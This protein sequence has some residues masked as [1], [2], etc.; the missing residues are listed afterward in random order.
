M[1]PRLVVY[2]PLGDPAVLLDLIDVYDGEGVD[3]VECGWPALDPYLDGPDVR[4]SMAR[5]GE[6]T[7]AWAAVRERRAG[8]DAKP[9]VDDLRWA[10]SYG[11][12]GAAARRLAVP[13]GR[14][15]GRPRRATLE[16]AARASGAKVCAFLPLPLTG[17]DVAEARRAD[18]YVMLQAAPGVTGPRPS[19]DPANTERLTRLRTSGVVAPVVLGFGISNGAQA[20]TA[21]GLGAD[22]VVVG[23]AALR[24]GARG[25]DQGFAEGLDG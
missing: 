19:L 25:L 20:R 9:V 23:S 5:A 6:P 4:D 3:I 2:F 13:R 15:A 22:G 7:A 10:G 12:R 24:T 11:R 21:V 1:P 17:A 8:V 16:A 18:G 14:P